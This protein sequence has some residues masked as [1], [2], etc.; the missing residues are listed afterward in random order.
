MQVAKTTGPFVVRKNSMLFSSEPDKTTGPHN[1]SL[2]GGTFFQVAGADEFNTDSQDFSFAARINTES[3]GTI[4]CKTIDQPNWMANGQTWFIRDGR[5]TFDIG[6]VGAVQSNRIVADGKWHDVV[7]TWRAQDAQVSFFVDGTSAGGGS[8]K[9]SE[10]LKNSVIRIGATNE[11]FPNR[12][13]FDGEIADVQLFERLLSDGEIETPTARLE[14]KRFG[15]WTD[16]SGETI[17]D[18]S[19]NSHAAFRQT[20][21]DSDGAP[22]GLRV[23]RF[24]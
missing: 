2:K 20:K 16:F 4:V 13:Y 23:E 5:Q 15:A 19:G 14:Q 17:A 6:W 18:I 22:I 8:L 1:G 24:H 10:P 11:N 9:V 3:D 7:M 21:V 12:S